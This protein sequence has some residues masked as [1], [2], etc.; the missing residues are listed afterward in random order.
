MAQSPYQMPSLKMMRSFEAAARLGS[1]K[2]AAVELHV[3]PS[4][5]SH[6]VKSLE[7]SLGIA[8]F[9]RANRGLD[10]TSEGWLLREAISRGFSEISK[11]IQTLDKE[12]DSQTVSIGATTA[13]STLWLTPRISQI[14]REHPEIT[15]NQDVRD[16][17]FSRPSHLDLIIE[18]TTDAPT[19]KVDILFDDVLV[20]LCAPSYAQPKDNELVTLAREN[21]IHLHAKETNWTSWFNWF[22]SL[23]YSGE[24]ADMRHVNNYAI[25][26]QLAQD[27]LG[28][29]LGW[30]R[31]VAPLVQAGKLV[32]FGNIESPAP[33]KFYLVN[34]EANQ[35]K[36]VRAVREQLLGE[37]N[38]AKL[39]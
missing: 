25:A 37:L 22:S 5:V 11:A 38:S 8:L 4:A 17:P 1:I 19:G 6:Q 15:I 24:I 12:R 32:P 31:L 18:Y 2:E 36:S 39:G 9:Y 27:G 14:W 30:K 13:V 34:N 23:G 29:V 10:L 35:S 21:L 33:G 7:Q 28:I 20:P 3:T 26:L 16:R